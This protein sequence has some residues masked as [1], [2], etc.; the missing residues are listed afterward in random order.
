MTKDTKAAET[1][2][3]G[4]D[5]ATLEAENKALA[6]DKKKLETDLATE[7]TAHGATKKSLQ[8][9]EADKTTLT[10]DKDKLTKDL[11]A[12]KKAHNSTKTKLAETEAKLQESPNGKTPEGLNVVYLQ[13]PYGIDKRFRCGIEVTPVRTRHEVDDDVLAA[14]EHDGAILVQRQ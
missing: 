7:K 3:P 10:A 5:L 6:A 8:D 12:E 11:D 2:V 14:L 13:T 9:A 4:K 1:E